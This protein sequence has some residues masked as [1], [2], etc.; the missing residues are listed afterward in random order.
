MCKPRR[1]L[2]RSPHVGPISSILI[3][4]HAVFDMVTIWNRGGKAGR[5]SLMRGDGMALVD[6][7]LPAGQRDEVPDE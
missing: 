6:L 7:L 3:E 2:A 5:L 1:F 4:V